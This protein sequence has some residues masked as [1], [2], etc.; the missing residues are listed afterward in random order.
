MALPP[1]RVLLAG[2]SLLALIQ[3]PPLRSIPQAAAQPQ[4]ARQAFP[5]LTAAQTR[6][7]SLSETD[8]VVVIMRDQYP[9][10]RSAQHSSV[11]PASQSAVL[12]ELGRVGA[13]AV[14]PYKVVNAVSATVSS[15]EAARLRADPAVLDVVPDRVIHLLSPSPDLTPAASAAGSGR[16]AS[17]A[18]D[19]PM[20]ACTT[21]KTPSLE[22]EALQLTN[23]AYADSRVAQA[24]QLRSGT[25]A[26][27]NG[28]GVK[29]AF[30]ADGV[31]IYNPDFMRNGK[32][33]FVDYKD[34][35]GDGPTAPTAG[36][37]A[38]L[39][40]SS[41]AA[42]GRHVYDVNS[43]R[44]NPL[45]KACPIRI[46]GMAPGAQLI[47]LKVFGQSNATTTSA[48]VQAIDY[49]ISVDEVD[50]LNESFGGNPF[51]DYQNDPISI[52]NSNAVS[53]GVT[54]TVSSGDAGAASTIGS[55]GS[56][57]GVIL[58]GAS[59]QFRAY[60]QV[61]A[62]GITL[63][64]GG[65]VDN[66][67][68]AISSGGFTQLGP[69]TV[70]V[71]APGDAGWALCT[72]SR[73]KPM[74]YS[75]CVDAD[76]S[77]PASIEFTGGTSESAPLT[78]GEAALVIQAYRSTHHGASPT[79]LLVKQIITSTATDLGL[80]A[81]EQGA[82]LINSYRAVQAALSYQDAVASPSPRAGSL[83]VTDTTAFTASDKPNT[84]ERLSFSV[85]NVGGQS[86]RVAPKL[87]TAGKTVFHA[88]YTLHL[89]PISDSATFLDQ[90]GLGRAFVTQTFRVPA[91]VQHL[92]AAIAWLALQESSSVV[93]LDLFDPSGRFAAFSD[94][95]NEPGYSSGFGQVSV[96]NPGA[97]VWTAVIWTRSTSATGSYFGK[98]QLSINGSRSATTG[99][100]TPAAVVL[101]PGHTATFTVVTRTPASPGDL[102]E[103]IAFPTSSG[104]GSLIGAI[105]VSLRSLVTLTRGGG[106][107]SGTLTGGNGRFGSPGQT[108]SYQFDVPSGLRDLD[109]GLRITDPSS[110][111]EGVLVD[112]NGQPVDVQ[113]TASAVSSTG[114]PTFYTGAMQF[115]RRD[116]LAGRWLFVL[117]INDAVGSAATA[118]PFHATI[119]FNGVRVLT[120]G[121][122]S[123]KRTVLRAGKPIIAAILVSNTGVTDEHLLL[124]P[125]LATTARVPLEAPDGFSVTLPI[126]RSQA[127]PPFVVP[128]EV[129]TLTF[130]AH[131]P[132]PV[133]F[134]AMLANGAPPFGGT[135]NPDI[136]QSSGS[137]LD[138]MSGDYV[139]TVALNT[140]EVAP[141]IWAVAPEQFGPFGSDGAAPST[142]DITASAIGQPFDRQVDT[143]TGDI[144][145]PFATQFQAL[146][147]APKHSGEIGIRFTP[148]GA[149]GTVVRGFLYLDTFN[150]SST[151]G[152]ELQAIPYT[153]TIGK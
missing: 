132:S 98:V 58:V 22:P 145:S 111:L 102:D 140:P 62:A 134:D 1:G 41:I 126:T 149:P 96:R 78:A 44:V 89:D 37:E 115:F 39:D 48:F 95:Q 54:V 34:F 77:T 93:R 153:Y 108:L 121:I 139:A 109:L 110:N 20:P 56:D 141:G 112:P 122:P 99:K 137:T 88:D 147:L 8:H 18:S 114:V 38:F 30:I 101:A 32:T 106:S 120:H 133:A 100:V 91:G 33:V 103:E 117:L 63:G 2:I 81:S 40:A 31:D 46:L 14:H 28:Q 17:S 7:L 49:A 70:D 3:L 27:I 19:P 26:L 12:Q 130:T 150:A 4:S 21:S 23:T 143:T 97:G 127:L 90:F 83:L 15:A 50:V 94:P 75:D 55:P 131:S 64:S 124:D 42:Q 118:Q 152:D 51:P 13:R 85:S 60:T 76:Q 80:P 35:S 72:P 87:R 65:Y 84:S 52:A 16:A 105:P 57:P 61:G 113:T 59:T 24:Q 92:N 47:G 128:P 43:Y 144:W 53:A 25:G 135:G 82:G 36:G 45:P 66:N 142:V 69:R 151:S 116:P 11:A 74:A 71:V 119:T 10:D 146:T 67:V 138:P 79:P 86:Q 6:Q 136:Y 104:S 148:S 129:S 125:R 73:V 5:A 107:F 9:A 68:A 29:V 123:S